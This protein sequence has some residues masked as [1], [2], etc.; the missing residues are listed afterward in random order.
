MAKETYGFIIMTHKVE[1]KKEFDEALAGEGWAIN[2]YTDLIARAQTPEEVRVLTH[3]RDEEKQHQK[4]LL[5]LM[6]CK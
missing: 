4:E 5:E 6:R 2:D 1:L 3:I